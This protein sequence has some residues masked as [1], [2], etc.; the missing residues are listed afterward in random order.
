[1]Y[2]LVHQ[3][4]PIY[5]TRIIAISASSGASLVSCNYTKICPQGVHSTSH[6]L[7][8]LNVSTSILAWHFT[9]FSQQPGAAAPHIPP[10]LPCSTAS[11]HV[12]QHEFVPSIHAQLE[13]PL[14]VCMPPPRHQFSNH[15]YPSPFM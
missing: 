14:A 1:M 4:M 2:L 15:S 8:K 10:L 11:I 7:N 9:R 12:G 6:L 5:T 13:I 3:R